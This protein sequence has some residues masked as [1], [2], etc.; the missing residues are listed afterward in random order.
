MKPVWVNAQRQ[1]RLLPQPFNSEFYI[2][3][4]HV[5]AHNLH[6]TSACEKM[7]FSDKN[8]FLLFYW[9]SLLSC[10]SSDYKLHPNSS[11]AN[12]T[13][14][15]WRYTQKKYLYFFLRAALVEIWTKLHTVIVGNPLFVSSSFLLN[16]HLLSM[17][18]FL[19]TA[20]ETRAP[21]LFGFPSACP[22]SLG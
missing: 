22:S 10:S 16:L 18:C 13:L 6:T 5:T 14:N 7:S 12:N 19:W 20:K 3:P 1:P 15:T 9:N 21:L 2:L 11:H 17:G 4:E 8:M